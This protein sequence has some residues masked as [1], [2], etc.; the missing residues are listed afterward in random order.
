MSKE[1]IKIEFWKDENGFFPVIEFLD[2]NLSEKISKQIHRKIDKV[3]STQSFDNLMKDG[4]RFTILSEYKIKPQPYELKFKSQF[5]RIV[6]K[7]EGNSL[8]LVE[9]VEGSFSNKK[10]LKKAIN[11]YIKRVC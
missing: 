6:S 11:I 8:I 7:R 4:D 2:N 9:G 1:N 3:I 10:L 5:V